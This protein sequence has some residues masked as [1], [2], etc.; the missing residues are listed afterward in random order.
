MNKILRGSYIE[1]R[2]WMGEDKLF[3]YDFD[4]FD[5]EIISIINFIISISTFLSG[6]VFIKSDNILAGIVTEPSSS[7]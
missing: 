3:H 7:I 4:Y 1:G 2:R 6:N 5:K